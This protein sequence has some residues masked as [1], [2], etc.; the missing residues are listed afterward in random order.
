V[1]RQSLLRPWL[2]IAISF[3]PA[4]VFPLPDAARSHRHIDSTLLF[5]HQKSNL[6]APNPPPIA[7]HQSHLPPPCPSLS[8]ARLIRSESAPAPPP[9]QDLGQ[10]IPPPLGFPLPRRPI[11]SAS[12]VSS[13]DPSAPAVSQSFHPQIWYIK[14]G[15]L[16]LAVLLSLMR[17]SP[18]SRFEN[19]GPLDGFS[20]R[21]EGRF[22]GIRRIDLIRAPC[23]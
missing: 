16:G 17:L 12:N 14:I 8:L 5:L 11:G 19:F 7:H 1:L 22:V 15:N 18:A 9:P 2:R 6:F 20:D 13:P 4:F 3:L 23:L 10:S 21:L